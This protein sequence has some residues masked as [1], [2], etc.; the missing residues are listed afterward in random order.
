MYEYNAYFNCLRT[1]TW[2]AARLVTKT[3]Q[4]FSDPTAPAPPPLLSPLLWSAVAFLWP[5]FVVVVVMLLFGSC[6][7]RLV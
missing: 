4:Q 7:E 2:L 1:L 6:L 5:V 3:W